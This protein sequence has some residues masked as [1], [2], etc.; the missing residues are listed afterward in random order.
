MKK[1]IVKQLFASCMIL[2]LALWPHLDASARP[3][4]GARPP[5]APAWAWNTFLGGAQWD[6][7]YAVAADA[8]GNIY[9]AGM[10]RGSW[11]TPLSPYKGQED[12][13]VAK[14]NSSGVLQWNTFLGSATGEDEAYA[15]AVDD[16][17]YVVVTGASTDS[18]GRPIAAHSEDSHDVFVARLN[19]SG[20]LLWN[21]F[22]GGA[23]IDRAYGVALNASNDIYVTGESHKSWGNPV[24]PP[25]SSQ[26]NQEAFVAKLNAHGVRQWNTFMGERNSEDYARGIAYDGNSVLVTGFSKKSWGSPV[27]PH[28]GDWYGDAFVAKLNSSNGQRQWNTFLGGLGTDEGMGVAVRA[29]HV[30]VTGY[31]YKAWGSPVAPFPGNSENAFVARLGGNGGLVW[32][33]FMGGG[34]W[35]DDRGHAITIGTNE[36]IYVVGKSAESWGSPIHPHQ[37][38]WDAFAAELNSDGS[39]AWNT[40]LGG[41]ST[42]YGFA[43]A[44][45]GNNVIVAGESHVAYG[46]WGSPVRPGSGQWDAFAVSIYTGPPLTEQLHL[47]L[48]LRSSASAASALL[49]PANTPP[50]ACFTFDPES[51][52]VGTRFIFDASCS[53]DAEDTLPWLSFR[54]DWNDNGYY[55]TGWWNASQTME[56]EFATL[57]TKTIKMLIKDKDGAT[58]T[59]TRTLQVDDPGDNTAPTAICSATPMSGTV[60][61][62]FTFSAATSTDTQD[63]QSALV[64]KWD[65]WDTGY[66]STDWLPISQTQTHQWDRHGMHTVRLRVRDTGLLSSDTG[67]T[68]EVVPDEPNT[69]PTACF[70]IDPATAIMGSDFT[71]DASCSH[72]AEDTLPWLAIRFDWDN[73]GNWD[74]AWWNASSTLTHRYSLPGVYTVRML[75]KD[76][77][78]LTDETTRTLTVTAKN[79]YLSLFRR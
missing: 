20:A 77:G 68:V 13:F 54:F 32:N 22:M 40:F 31:S 17:G 44:A 19:P 43:V 25:S 51:G 47:P 58:D 48:M 26:L 12:A 5:S 37:S 59:T 24:N 6:D 63:P 73:D 79:L 42:D 69:P 62:I 35:E 10:S 1:R 71:F 57:G 15:I 75:V 67:C 56:H 23:G 41:D 53:H 36:K 46:D 30:Y 52:V 21:T 74:M 45:A 72:D 9:V 39:R 16:N 34:N 55:D 18:W 70:T 29:D 4:P 28:S 11:G 61:T 8:T 60:D 7:G 2:T 3:F 76:S 14:L 64:A 65:W 66:W 38:D 50:T 27:R 33:T 78:D 49:Q